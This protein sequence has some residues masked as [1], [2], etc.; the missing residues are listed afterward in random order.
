MADGN[1]AFVAEGLPHSLEAEMALLGIL[2]IDN[3]AYERLSHTRASTFFE[4]YNGRIFTALEKQIRKGVLADPT[5]LAADLQS[6]PAFHE[7]GGM[8]Y[9][10]GLVRD[11][12][13]SAY[14]L[15]YAKTLEE[16]AARRTLINIGAEISAAARAGEHPASE[17]V[18]EAEQTLYGLAEAGEASSGPRSFA[19]AAAGALG[20]AAEA[21]N[22]DGG[23]TGIATE[24]VDLDQKI[25]GLQSPDL[26]ILAGRPAMGKSALAGNIAH[27]VAQRYAYQDMPDGT[28]KTV[29]G[30]RVLLYSLEMSKEQLAMRMLA[31]AAGVSSD[32]IRKGEIQ[33]HEFGKVRDAAIELQEMPLWIDDTGGI[34]LSKLVAR[35]RRHK[36]QYG[37]D[38]IVVD[39][40]QLVT[41]TLGAGANRVQQVS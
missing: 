7:T 41:S 35:A 1:A 14:V 36:R 39:Y 30:G 40:L 17:L 29:S 31:A 10:A 12:P 15:D 33:A 18:E 25:G 22:R 20:M 3:G 9:F 34:S 37:L 27:T 5:L 19:E 16:L 32:R 24:L 28:R 13:P 8:A 4:P 21:Y 23:I 38:L 11:A 26:I 6:D 2:L